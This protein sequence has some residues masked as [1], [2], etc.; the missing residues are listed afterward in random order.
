MPQLGG[1][2]ERNMNSRE[3]YIK[4]LENYKML[5]RENWSLDITR[6]KPCKEQLDLSMDLFSCINK[7]DIENKAMD[8]RNYGLVD[9]IPE[10]KE[11]F[12][13]LLG[14]AADEIL[15]GGNSTL[16]LIYSLLI[17]SCMFGVPG[18]KKPWVNKEKVKFLCPCPGY[19]RHFLILEKMGIEMINIEMTEYGPDMDMV[20]KL[21]AEDESIKGI[22]CVPMYSNPTG[23]TYSDEVVDRLSSM[24]VKAP[25]FRI[26]WDNAYC[27]HHI[28]AKH[29]KLT[30]IFSTCKKYK[31]E[32]RV[33]M[34]TST[35]KISFPGAGVAVLAASIKNLECIKNEISVQTIGPDKINQLRHVKYFNSID[36]IEEHMKKHAKIIKP[37]FDLVHEYFEKYLKP[38]DI[39]KWSYPKGG[40][41]INL[42]VV[43]GCA[44]KIVT[45]ASEAGL[46]LTPV[47]ATF[48]Y[49]MDPYDRNIRIAPTFLG[50]EQLN[51]ALDILCSCILVVTL[52]KR[53]NEGR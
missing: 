41:F 1:G 42:D 37:K 34:F 4:E 2:M 15:V 24:K 23:I 51:K 19:D 5:K 49:R 25:D 7:K 13:Q 39:A 16:S 50:I 36:K 26:Y 38:F 33:Y 20:E 28:E 14:V 31:N 27:I 12:S 35:S 53:Y 43:D 44:S 10:A 11:I 46:K 32:E 52:E 8:Y 18:V 48:P 22:I 47:G 40:Y 17:N 3:V 30:N 29:D 6:G 9:G 21:S 45:M